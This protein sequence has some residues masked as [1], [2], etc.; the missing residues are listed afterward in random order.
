MSATV[1]ADWS[2]ANEDDLR[3]VNTVADFSATDVA[4]L[5]ATDL[6]DLSATDIADFRTVASVAAVKALQL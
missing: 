4:D 3:S 6:A 5:S 2:P 1:V